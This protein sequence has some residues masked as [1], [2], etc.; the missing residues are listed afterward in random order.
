M[1]SPWIIEHTLK[2]PALQYVTVNT[3]TVSGGGVN[4]TILVESPSFTSP[5]VVRAVLEATVDHYAS[6]NRQQVGFYF[7]YWVKEDTNKNGT[8]CEA[9]EPCGYLDQHTAGAFYGISGSFFYAPDLASTTVINQ[10]WPVN[11]GF[12]FLT[13]PG[14]TCAV[15]VHVWPA[16]FFT[17]VSRPLRWGNV[18][19]RIVRGPSDGS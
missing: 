13:T 19:L 3:P 18:R 9:G 16:H 6:L 7:A 1:F 10:L 17:N 11:M 12:T 14:T 15:E 5:G 2:A 4:P 8:F